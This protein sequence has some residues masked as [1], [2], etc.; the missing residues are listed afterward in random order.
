MEQAGPLVGR[1]PLNSKDMAKITNAVSRPKEVDEM[2]FTSVLE[3]LLRR[4][5]SQIRGVETDPKIKEA[6]KQE[7]EAEQLRAA[8]LQTKLSS[9]FRRNRNYP[10]LRDEALPKYFTREERQQLRQQWTTRLEKEIMQTFSL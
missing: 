5:Q 8:R 4:Y 2:L 3:D 10:S 6:L 7:E 1:R 9:E